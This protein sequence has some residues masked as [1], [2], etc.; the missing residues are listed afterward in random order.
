[1]P[2]ISL[3]LRPVETE[4]AANIA[5]LAAVAT[6][7]ATMALAALGAA[8]IWA[9]APAMIVVGLAVY[10]VLGTGFEIEGVL[11]AAP[12]EV[13]KSDYMPLGFEFTTV[14]LVRVGGDPWWTTASVYSG[15]DLLR[16]R[17]ACVHVGYGR[18]L[19]FLVGHPKAHLCLAREMRRRRIEVRAEETECDHPWCRAI[20]GDL[21]AA[22]AIN[23]L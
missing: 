13:V 21:L 16:R 8:P 1:M 18:W 9:V 23:S 17:V 15:R 3:R 12:C 2:Y 4:R 19:C 22:Q 20:L 6:G 7:L 14:L 10:T 11:M 5:L